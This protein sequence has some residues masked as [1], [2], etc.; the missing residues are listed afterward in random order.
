MCTC[1]RALAVN[2]KKIL[3]GCWLPQVIESIDF[4]RSFSSMY[5]SCVGDK[6][7]V[8]SETFSIRK[9]K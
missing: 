6:Y 3:G 8:E 9:K 4:I 2:K 1:E 5:L 7:V